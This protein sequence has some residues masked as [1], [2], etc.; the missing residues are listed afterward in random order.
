MPHLPRL[1]PPD[2]RVFFAPLDPGEEPNS[3]RTIGILVADGTDNTLVERVQAA[4][5]K[6]RA[7]TEIVAPTID[8]AT[9]TDDMIPADRDLG[10]A[11]A[12]LFDA[13]V[14]LLS[15]DATRRLRRDRTVVAWIRD[16]FEHLKAI[17]YSADAQ[18]LFDH[19]GIGP[20][21]GVIALT[22]PRE[23]SRFISAARRGP[24]WSIGR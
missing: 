6:A 23:V 4:A 21:E 18:P 15:R 16:A 22:C 8:G 13:V 19:A 5:R 7:A 20:D 2:L 12:R 17:G 11:P 10:S 9:G 1:A 24:A 3:T 14:V